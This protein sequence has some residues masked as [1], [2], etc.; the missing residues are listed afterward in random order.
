VAQAL[1]TLLGAAGEAL[2][3]DRLLK[4]NTVKRRTHS[5]YRQGVHYYNA[6]PRMRESRLVPLV[7]KFA[8]LVRA[9][10]ICIEIFGII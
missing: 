6:I 8:E 1:L 9:Q 5:L 4:A 3:M 2:G 10:A 7:E